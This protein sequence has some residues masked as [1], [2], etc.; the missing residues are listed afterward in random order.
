MLLDLARGQQLAEAEAVDAGVVGNGGQVL[1]ARVAQR[2]DQR[3]GNAAQAEAADGDGL[4]VLDDAGKR[5]C[6][7]GINFLH[8]VPFV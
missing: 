2:S 8:G 7:I 3:L 1:D 6:R 5:G 4:P